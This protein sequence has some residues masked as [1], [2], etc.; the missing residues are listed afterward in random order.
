MLRLRPGSTIVA[1][2]G[3][4]VEAVATI[5]GLSAR[6]CSASIV[7]L[8]R[9]D[10]EPRQRVHIGLSMLRG[11]QTP[12][13]VQKLTELGV[14]HITLLA[15]DHCVIALR[16]VQEQEQRVERLQRIAV[17]AAEQA[18]RVTIPR[19]NGPISAT[20]FFA[21]ARPVVLLERSDSRHLATWAQERMR[22]GDVTTLAI[23]PEGGWSA[24]EREQIAALGLDTAHLG[25]LI[26]RAE[27]CA[28]AALTT[29]LHQQ[30]DEQVPAV[31]AA[32]HEQI[33]PRHG[34]GDGEAAQHGR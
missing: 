34:H 22:T 3:S 7:S 8:E 5:D 21:E 24:A 17:E 33:E 30:G 31:A 9:P 1:F 12:M 6:E 11:D 16:T 25:R 2:D 14:E 20:A 19:L 27:T 13:A 23:G 4:G 10:R 18:E 26:L 29:V 32:R 15:A 28:I